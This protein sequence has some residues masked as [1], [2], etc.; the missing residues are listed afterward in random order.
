MSSAKITLSSFYTWFNTAS[1]ADDLFKNME[2]P[3]GIDKDT[4]IADILMRGGEFEVMYAD[5]YFMQSLIGPWSKKWYRTFE[6]WVKALAIDYNPLENYDRMEEWEDENTGTLTNTRTHNNQDKRTLNTENKTTHNTTDKTTYNSTD[7]TT[8]DGNTTTTE[9]V[10]AYDSDSYQ[11][12]KQVTTDEDTTNTLK[13]TGNDTLEKTGTD[14]LN[15]TGTDTVDY[16][17][18]IKDNGGST[19]KGKHKGR[20]H[21][22]VGVTTSQQMLL[23]ELDLSQWNLYEHI[24]DIFLSDFV[25]PIYS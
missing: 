18:T 25:I 4:L 24:S 14:T 10:S 12:S 19:D 9:E 16:S 15:N 2:L 21:G 5:P 22:N 6:K 17:G 7:T 1:P 3:A 13:R 23:S 8:I 11:P 20:I